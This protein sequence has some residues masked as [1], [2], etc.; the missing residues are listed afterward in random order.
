MS[1]E[2]VKT[3]YKGEKHLFML[4]NDRI[5]FRHSRAPGGIAISTGAQFHTHIF[6]E[7]TYIVE[8]HG[9]H[10]TENK[11]YNLK[12]GTLILTPPGVHHKISIDPEKN[13]DRYYIGINLDDVI[14]DGNFKRTYDEITIIDCSKIP[15]IDGIF[16]R[17]DYYADTFDETVFEE[18]AFILIK[19]LLFNLSVYDSSVSV[20]YRSIHPILSK[21]LDYINDN[22]ISISSI[23]DISDHLY[24]TERY[25]YELFKTQ[26]MTTPKKYINEKKLH[27][28]RQLLISG[29]KPGE[30]CFKAGFS[31]YSSFYRNYKKYFKIPPSV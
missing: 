13:Y 4:R 16:K 27:L 23:K 7:I 19:E 15:M 17:S 5:C 2:S 12:N 18:M 1:N 25:L 3:V 10:V 21:T 26:L 28:A 8:G 29:K 14:K 20:D 6:T 24:V 9:Y 30:V 22:L 31:D 11:E